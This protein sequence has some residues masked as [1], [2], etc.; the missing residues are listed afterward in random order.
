[1]DEAYFGAPGK[2]GKRNR[3]A[4][5][6]PVLADALDRSLCAWLDNKK[7]WVQPF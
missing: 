4:T 6:T 5:K 3:G 2:G 1:M 7:R